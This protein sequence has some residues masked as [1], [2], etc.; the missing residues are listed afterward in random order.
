MGR[1]KASKPPPHK[2]KPYAAFVPRS[3]LSKRVKMFD[4]V[5]LRKTERLLNADIA[6]EVGQNALLEDIYG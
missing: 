2:R 5:F 3:A 6:L 1:A 4:L